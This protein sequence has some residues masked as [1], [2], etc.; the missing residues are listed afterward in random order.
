MFWF[1][2]TEALGRSAKKKALMRCRRKVRVCLAI[3]VVYDVAEILTF[4]TNFLIFEIRPNLK[5]SLSRKI[6]KEIKAVPFM[7]PFC[8]WNNV[9]YPNL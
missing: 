5:Q 3:W 1:F 6:E 4:P 7:M 9:N 2:G 8:Y